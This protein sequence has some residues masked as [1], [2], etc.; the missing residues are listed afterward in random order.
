MNSHVV[1]KCRAFDYRMLPR[2]RQPLEF[3]CDPN[4]EHGEP[5][6]TWPEHPLVEWLFDFPAARELILQE[7]NYSPK[8]QSRCQLTNPFIG[9]KNRKPGDVDVLIWEKTNPHEAA[10]IECKRT[11]VKVESFS[12]G[13]VNGLGNLEEGVTQANELFGLGFHRTYLA[14]LT[15]VQGRER[16]KFNVLGR[17]MTDRQFKKIYRCSSFGELR[18]EIGIIF[19]EVVKPTSRSLLEM[20]QIGVVVDKRAIPRSQPSDLTNKIQSLCP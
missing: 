4:P 3:F 1:F 2:E 8:A 14:I 18:S 16:T 20:A 6:E 5:E 10:V 19:V 13:D 15:I 17:G 12:S 7:L 11:K 9:N